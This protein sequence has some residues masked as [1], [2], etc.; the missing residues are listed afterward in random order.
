MSYVIW[1]RGTEWGSDG[2]FMVVSASPLDAAEKLAA[3]C[4]FEDSEGNK[5]CP[6]YSWEDIQDLAGMDEDKKEDLESQVEIGLRNNW[7]T[8]KQ[9]AQLMNAM[10]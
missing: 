3:D 9:A 10:K 1:S 6:S 8:K 5:V 4:N 2:M 7:I